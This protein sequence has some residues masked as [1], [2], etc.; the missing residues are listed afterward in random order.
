MTEIRE[1]KA[2]LDRV[3]ATFDAA[4]ANYRNAHS[5]AQNLLDSQP[6]GTN[7][8]TIGFQMAEPSAG[9]YATAEITGAFAHMEYGDVRSL[10]AST[11]C[12]ASTTQS[13]TN[14]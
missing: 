10:R 1:N 9:A 8:I 14:P 13:R 12:S 2:E 6:L 5:A 7:N 11:I 3:V 4:K